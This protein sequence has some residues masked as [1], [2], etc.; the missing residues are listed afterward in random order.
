LLSA[1]LILRIKHIYAW[2]ISNKYQ[3]TI[4]ILLLLG[5]IMLLNKSLFNDPVSTVI[6][7]NSGNLL[8]ARVADDGQWRFPPS[9]SVTEKVKMATLAFEDRYYYF[10]PG[11]NP[12]S[13]VRALILNLKAGKVMSG[14]ST[15]T[16][17]TIRLSRKG[18]PRSIWEKVI[19]MIMATRLELG[20][21]KEEILALYTSHAPYGGNVVGIEA[22]S[23]RY[24]AASSK[25][26]SWAEAATL[27]V[28]PNAPALVHPG[29]NRDI[30]MQKRNRL[31]IRM[32]KLG[33]INNTTLYTSM[34]EDIPE[35]PKS[36]P[37]LAPHLLDRFCREYPGKIINT[38]VDAS[39]QAQVAQL[40]EVH[41]NKLRYNEIHNAAAIIL[42]VNTGNVL[43]YIGNCGYVNEVAHAN[44]VDIILSPRSTGSLLKPLLFAAMLDDGKLLPGSL[45]ADIPINLAGFAPQNFNGQFEGAL[46]A[47]R[48][49]SRSLNVPAVQM[50]KQYGVERFHHLIRALGMNT[51]NQSSDYYGLSL[52]LGGAEGTLEE[53][54]NIYAS[55]SR[56]LNHYGQT[57]SYYTEDYRLPNFIMNSGVISKK[58][59]KQVSLFNASSIWFTYQAMIEVNRPEEESGWQHFGSARKIAWKTGT[60]FGY[61]DGW[62]IGTSADYVVGVWVGNAD[63]EGRPGLTGIAAAAPLLFDIFGLLPASD[64]FLPPADELIP[65][66]V[67]KTSGY[68]AGPYCTDRDTVKIPIT[69]IRSP[70]CP[71][72]RLIHLSA[73]GNFRVTSDCCPVDSMRHVSWFVLPPIQEWYYKKRHSDYK[74]LPHYRSGCAPGNQKSMDLIYPREEIKIFIPRA[75]SGMK[76][77]VIF[78]AVHTNPDAFIYW[79]LDNQFIAATKFIHQVEL[80]PAAGKH[81][82]VLVDENGEE[83]IK[84]FEVVE[85]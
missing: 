84:I 16:M 42:E 78:E 56:V 29:K 43:A 79:H 20:R 8:G 71:F 77:K 73:D 65:A 58:G 75:L 18:K 37:R 51:V 31:L 12:V 32:N 1:L 57:G 2:L 26:L 7:D 21:S 76:E 22:A 6:L 35:K 62:A 66:I 45:V 40:V 24:F 61:R 41:H 70:A 63:G 80:L 69:G 38:T 36:M 54:S 85:P 17:Q 28:L 33:W 68:L 9:D 47:G 74:L 44:D 34:T 19:E 5:Y 27:A 67:C 60:S 46:P 39:L 55:L 11:I 83:L 25:N 4:V 13:L 3:L 64:S 53:M 30:L 52:I 50:L 14:G 59:N 81:T 49:L 72:H 15:I 10:H 23:W 82:L 48:A